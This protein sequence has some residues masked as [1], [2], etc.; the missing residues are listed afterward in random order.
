MEP[1]VYSDDSRIN[2]MNTQEDYDTRR[3]GL[4]V[5]AKIIAPIIAPAPLFEKKKGQSQDFCTL[6]RGRPVHADHVCI[7]A[8]MQFMRT[9]CYSAVQ[10]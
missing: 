7:S 5:R 8:N 4:K 2:K 6:R 10:V 1:L 3:L 9:T